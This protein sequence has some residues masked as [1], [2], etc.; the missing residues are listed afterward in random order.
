M[1]TTAATL[2]AELCARLAPAEDLGVGGL[3]GIEQE[4]TVRARDAWAVDFRTVLPD[5][6]GLAPPLDPDDP[7]ARR[8]ASGVVLTADGREAEAATPPVAV[9]PGFTDDV[10]AWTRAARHELA[11]RLDEGYT[12]EGYSTHLSIAADDRRSARVGALFTRTLTL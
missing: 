11:S 7:R 3:V 12:L 10:A 9:R 5:L 2:E 8:T 1:D 6:D 4:F